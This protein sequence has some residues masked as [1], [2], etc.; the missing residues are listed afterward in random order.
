MKPSIQVCLVFLFALVIL[1]GCSISPDELEQDEFDSIAR[2]DRELIFDAQENYTGE[3][4]LEIAMAMALKY[5]LENRVRLLEEAVANQ[6]LDM[7]QMDLLPSLAASAGYLERDTLNASTSVSVNTGNVSLEPSTSQDLESIN[8]NGRFTWNLL[9]FGVSYLQAKQDADRYLVAKKAREKVMLT[10]LKEV[11]SAYWKAVA[12]DQMRGDLEAISSEV[13]ELLGYWQSVRDQQLRAPVAVLMDIRALIETRQQ[14]DEIKRTIETAHARLASLINAKDS[15]GL[16]LPKTFTFPELTEISEDVESMELIALGN[17]ADYA[18]EVYKVRIDQLES[19]KAMLRLLPGLEFSYGESYDDNSFL[20]NSR[21]GELGLNLTGDLTQLMFTSRIKKFRETNEELSINRKLAVNMAVITGLHISWQDYRNS[22]TSLERARYL[23]E[24]DEEISSLTRN[25]ELNQKETGAAA[26]QSELRAFRSK[27]GQM[28]S[29]ADAQGA[30]GTFVVSLGVNPIPDD[31]QR[32]SVSELAEIVGHQLDREVFPF[33]KNGEKI[34]AER[35]KFDQWVEKK[36][37][38]QIAQDEQ[39]KKEEAIVIA[40]ADAERMVL[41]QAESHRLAEEQLM[42]DLATAKAL[43][44]RRLAQQKIA[45]EKLQEERQ[46]QQLAQ[47]KALAKMEEQAADEAAIV[48]ARAV[49]RRAMQDSEKQQVAAHAGTIAPE[50]DEF[51]ADF[52]VKYFPTPNADEY[53]RQFVNSVSSDANREAYLEMFMKKMTT[54]P[55]SKRYMRE[56]RS[57]MT[58]PSTP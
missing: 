21:W 40:E 1:A 45:E 3:L 34:L 33:S 50:V 18:G 47:E 57:L 11:R 51:I 46:R 48:A 32:Y 54:S 35:A 43:E 2:R 36:K 20:F 15:R 38:A 42:V 56:F 41:A 55:D 10:L 37:E 30:F 13:D 24:I 25:A 14:L 9:D 5:N 6:Q 49:E 16:E 17:S 58:N 4:T 28:Q 39:R 22:L 29:Y 23:Q 44:D 52:W 19:R 53:V 26:I 27:I 12:M 8:A 31:Y 7:S